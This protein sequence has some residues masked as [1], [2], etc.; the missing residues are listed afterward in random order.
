MFSD[1]FF[2]D[3]IF[4]EQV[5][6]GERAE[7]KV[8]VH[9]VTVDLDKVHSLRINH[10]VGDVCSRED[11]STMGLRH[12]PSVAISL[13]EFRRG[14]RYNGCPHGLLV[15]DSFVYSDA[16]YQKPLLI[17]DADEK[18]ASLEPSKKMSWSVVIGDKVVP[19]DRVNQPA[20]DDEI[21]LYNSL[22]GRETRTTPHGIELFVERGRLNQVWSFW[23]NALIPRQG[24][25][26]RIGAKHPLA[27]FDWSNYLGSACASLVTKSLDLQRDNIF[28]VQGL[29]TLVN[30]GCIVADVLTQRSAQGKVLNFADELVD[31]SV[32]LGANKSATVVGV[33]A[34]GIL[35]IL[36]LE[37]NLFEDYLEKLAQLAVAQGCSD[38]MLMTTGGDVGLW[39][40]TQLLY[41]AEKQERPISD[42]LLVFENALE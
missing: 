31:N 28:A 35:K 18:K 8:K 20:G 42:A 12:K 27:S 41:Q 11:L 36:V 25:V 38:A 29:L 34:A 24:Y 22:F 2:A 6:F 7:S 5:L 14:G 37:N 16:G 26:L 9:V 17:I 39:L 1:V 40:K 19:V 15:I 32:A 4:Y 13:G 23:G 21:V 10:A 30:N 3:G 33:T